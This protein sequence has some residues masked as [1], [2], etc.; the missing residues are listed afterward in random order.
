MLE[1]PQVLG[2]DA[3]VDIPLLPAVDPILVPLLGARRLDEELHLHLFELAGAENEV[4]GRDLVAEALADLTDAER[5]LAARGGH[6]IGKVHEDALR[7]LGPQIVQAF[8]GFDRAEVRLQHHVEFA[9]F[10]PL[11]RVTG[12]G[13]ANVGQPVGRRMAVLGLV[14]LDEMVCAITLVRDQRLHQ[15]VVEHLDVAGCH[16]HFARQDDRGV[17]ADDVVATGDHRAPP[18]P[19]DVLL[20]FHAKRSVVPRRFRASV[21]LAG[22]K[23]KTTPLGHVRDGVDDGSHGSTA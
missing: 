11:A 21:D 1:Q 23:H 7:G 15:R 22:L 12:V 5:R 19:L 8:L 10:G 13:I 16:P 9:R 14:R 6:H 17:E 18:L 2:V 3:E 4:T 20:E